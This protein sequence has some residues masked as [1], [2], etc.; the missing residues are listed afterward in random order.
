M[1]S[2]SALARYVDARR[3]EYRRLSLGGATTSRFAVANLALALGGVML[4]FAHGVSAL[5]DPDA[6]A[7]DPIELGLVAEGVFFLVDGAAGMV[8]VRGRQD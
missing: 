5:L 7:P 6:P 1:A 2:R 3:A 4:I 8:A